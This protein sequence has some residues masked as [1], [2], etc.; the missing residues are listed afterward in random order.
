MKL[1][2]QGQAIRIRI[3]EDE[4]ARLFAGQALEDA[5]AWPDGARLTR[6]LVLSEGAPASFECAPGRWSAALPRQAVEAYA[7]GLSR[8]EGLSFSW[9][10]SDRAGIADLT[11]TLEVDVR[12]STRK[13]IMEPRARQAVESGKPPAG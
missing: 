1:Q 13:R 8:R 3:D 4:L 6:A 9:P 2:I 5:T 10:M 7:S 11:L 12:D